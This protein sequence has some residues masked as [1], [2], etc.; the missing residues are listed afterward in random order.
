LLTHPAASGTR[1]VKDLEAE[2]EELRATIAR[3]TQK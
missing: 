2:N 1:R 3:L